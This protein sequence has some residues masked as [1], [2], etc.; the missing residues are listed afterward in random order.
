MDSDNQIDAKISQAAIDAFRL[1]LSNQ[2]STSCRPEKHEIELLDFKLVFMYSTSTPDIRLEVNSFR[3]NWDK[4]VQKFTPSKKLKKNKH[5]KLLLD[6]ALQRV[7]N[8]QKA[9]Q[10][11]GTKT[12][13][14]QS[15]ETDIPHDGQPGPTQN[16]AMDGVASQQLF[17]QVPSNDAA[18]SDRTSKLGNAA[19]PASTDLL[20]RLA[21]SAKTNSRSYPQQP[22]GLREN[23]ETAG[24][25]GSARVS[26]N[27]N[28]D[29]NGSSRAASLAPVVSGSHKQQESR[30]SQDREGSV[31]LGI[32]ASQTQHETA[33]RSQNREAASKLHEHADTEML[34]FQKPPEVPENA[35]PRRIHSPLTDIEPN[36]EEIQRTSKKRQRESV[37]SQP[38]SPEGGSKPKPAEGSPS[39]KRRT[40]VSQETSTEHD[41]T[42]VSNNAKTQPA[43]PEGQNANTDSGPGQGHQSMRA[44]PWEGMQSIPASE[45]TIPADQAEILN[46]RLCWIPPAAGDP[47]PQ[48]HV[49]PSLLKQWNHIATRRQR[50]VEEAETTAEQPPSPTQDTM[51]WSSSE[52]EDES[53]DEAVESLLSW[54]ASPERPHPRNALPP[55]S[56]P[57]KQ[58]SST[59]REPTPDSTKGPPGDVE[60]DSNT[61]ASEGIQK[62]EPENTKSRTA[63]CA[64]EGSAAED[65][66]SQAQS[67]AEASDSARQSQGSVGDAGHRDE[68]FQMQ[69]DSAVTENQ[70]PTTDQGSSIADVRTHPEDL[71]DGIRTNDDESGDESDESMMEAS[72]PLGLGE[73]WPET[74][75]STQAEQEL[76]SSGP[77]LSAG[78]AG[79]TFGGHVHVAVTPMINNSRMGRSEPNND[80]AE[81]EHSQSA[82]SSSQANKMSSQSRIL[83]TYPHH[84]SYEKSRSSREGL[85]PSSLQSEEGSVRVDVVGTQTQNSSSLEMSQVGTQSQEIVLDSSGPAQRHQDIS[86]SAPQPAVQR[87]RQLLASPIAQTQS[88]SNQP[89]QVSEKDNFSQDASASSQQVSPTRPSDTTFTGQEPAQR[90]Q[91]IAPSGPRFAVQRQSQ[92]FASPAVPS[93]SQVDNP[94]QESGKSGLL[95]G[96]PASSPQGSPIPHPEVAV[97]DQE[98]ERVSQTT[99]ENGEEESTGQARLNT[100]NTPAVAHHVGHI[101]KEDRFAEANKAYKE[102]CNHYPV[103]TG[104]F[105][106]FAE[107]CFK[108]Y[109]L[110]AQG[111]LQQSFLWDD[112][113]IM[114]LL[115]YPSHIKERASQGS[116]LLSYED[117]FCLNFT[118]PLHKK[119]IL[120]ARGIDHAASQ[121][122]REDGASPAATSRIPSSRAPSKPRGTPRES[123]NQSFTTSLVNGFTNFHAHSFN[124]V[125]QSSL[126]DPAEPTAMPTSHPSPIPIKQ[127]GDDSL[128]FAGMANIPSGSMDTDEVKDEQ[129]THSSLQSTTNGFTHIPHHTPNTQTNGDISMDEI[130]ETDLE[131]EGEGEDEDEHENNRH[132]T[133][134]VELGDDPS[135]SVMNSPRLLG[136]EYDTRPEKEE[137][138]FFSLRHM[139]PSE[140]VWSDDPNTPFKRFA[141]ASM[142]AWSERSRRGGSKVLLDAKGVI[143]RL[144]HR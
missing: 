36:G 141:E 61:Q 15:S 46:D 10:S 23:T 11:D 16:N 5:V 76:R 142:N 63:Q 107:L 24:V 57:L 33:P 70:Q 123:D 50:L 102:F 85:N 43:R 71:E 108:L 124:E 6:R 128:D 92:L 60:A 104:D 111:K 28:P 26:V 52:D 119:S 132:G 116:G 56:S 73:S 82:S 66:A 131:D 38:R 20:Q 39:K 113:I 58:S 40:E 138:W 127:E 130:E 144:I 3:I 143:R 41:G 121:F 129:P 77:S 42:E 136:E 109:G 122:A 45:V 37:E 35:F 74:T 2:Q 114:H 27:G 75:Q 110:R 79:G 49:P 118:H 78:T 4:G 67:D 93:Q 25:E 22:S 51:M 13:L 69:D 96:V 87:Q 106:H 126:P 91:D 112:F 81:T 83:N 55:C 19:L 18:R 105:N 86:P 84:G 7:K 30:R 94:T 21:P 29:N 62:P 31:N 125:P 1:E 89:T 98:Q 88:Q 12:S 134:S 9:V 115:Q 99:P 90:H 68:D 14:T 120:T 139:E 34:S 64:S 100:Q 140:P 133:A 65:T 95:Q 48:G 53:D 135:D 17:S 44:D 117:Y 80:Q 32:R 59:R 103:Y 101:N 8:P 72:V 137:N 47:A 54:D 97:G